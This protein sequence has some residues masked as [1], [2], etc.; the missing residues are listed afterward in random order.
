MAHHLRLLRGPER[1]GRF[2]AIAILLPIRA[3]L[4]G[5]LDRREEKLRMER[6][7]RQFA[8][9]NS[10]LWREAVGPERGKT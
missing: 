6:E 1:I 5:R 8:E 7:T 3:L 2:G 10:G 9:T 4:N